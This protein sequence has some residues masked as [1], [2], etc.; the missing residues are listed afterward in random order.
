MNAIARPRISQTQLLFGGLRASSEAGESP[1]RAAFP[2][3]ATR[4]PLAAPKTWE[5]FGSTCAFTRFF[6]TGKRS[7]QPDSSRSE[8]HVQQSLG[9]IGCALYKNIQKAQA[10]AAPHLMNFST[11]FSTRTQT[12]RMLS[13]H[14][15]EN[16]LFFQKSVHIERRQLWSGCSVWVCECPRYSP[17][18]AAHAGWL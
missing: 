17:R 4:T 11:S 13:C 9:S 6:P 10:V 7:I 12:V 2:S 14:T 16:N 8:W 18:Y 3:L 15:N 5:A 1:L